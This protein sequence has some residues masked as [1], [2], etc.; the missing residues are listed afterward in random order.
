MKTEISRQSWNK[1]QTA[2]RELLL[3]FTQH[4]EAMVMFFVQHAALHTAAVD[5][6]ITWSYEDEI[7]ERLSDEAARRIPS[8]GEHSIVWLVWHLARIED[9]TM[10]ILVVGGTQLLNTGGWQQKL[11][12][13]TQDAGNGMSPEGIAA[14][15]AGIDIAALRAYRQAVG[16]N[17]RQIVQG[18]W[19]E[20][21]KLKVDP[22]RL[23]RVVDEGAVL[24]PA[25]QG[26]IEYW[27]K[28]TIAGLLLMPAT[29]HNF[30][31]LNEAA[32]IKEKLG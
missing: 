31:H 26:V 5:P 17:T 4:D 23:Q 7:F 19:P 11:K 12:I 8:G 22:G 21:L 24:L 25:G 10:N 16:R 9:I 29:R 20:A 2:F 14:L 30:I 3:T 27:G 15:S 13:S 6:E 32:K 1:Q 28:R 18:L